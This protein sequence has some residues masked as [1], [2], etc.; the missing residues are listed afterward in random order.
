MVST[1]VKE[2]ESSFEIEFLASFSIFY[3]DRYTEND[4]RISARTI[5]KISLE[6]T[7]GF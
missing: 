7:S 3:N 2:I 4:R 6:K 5:N 1:F